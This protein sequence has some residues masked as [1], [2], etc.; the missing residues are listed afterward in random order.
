MLLV[1]GVFCACFL[2]AKYNDKDDLVED[3]TDLIKDG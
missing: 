3:K 1:R 2:F